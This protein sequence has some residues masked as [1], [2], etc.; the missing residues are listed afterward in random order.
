M[1]PCTAEPDLWFS[2]RDDDQREAKQACKTCP[3][4]EA[5]MRLVAD[6]QPEFGVWAGRTADER[7]RGRYAGT[8]R[9]RPVTPHHVSAA[10]QMCA[11]GFTR[12]EAARQLGVGASALQKAMERARRTAA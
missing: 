8:G 2:T 1:T 11:R 6:L 7:S 4:L 12:P 9:P 3:A 10:E 5:C